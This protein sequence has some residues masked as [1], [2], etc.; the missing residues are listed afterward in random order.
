M[1]INVQAQ[2]CFAQPIKIDRQTKLE[3]NWTQNEY[4]NRRKPQKWIYLNS[5]FFQSVRHSKACNFG[6]NQYFAMIRFA[7]VRGLNS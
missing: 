7:A 3:V 6:Y 4:F 2:I 5:R 1:P